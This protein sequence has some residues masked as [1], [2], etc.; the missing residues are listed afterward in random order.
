GTASVPGALL[1]LIARALN[2]VDAPPFD[3]LEAMSAALS[4]HE[5]GDRDRIVRRLIERIAP[6]AWAAGTSDAQHD[7][8]RGGAVTTEYRRLLREADERLYQQ[9]LALE[10]SAAAPA[11]E[12][13][14]SHRT[15]VLAV[16][17]ALAMLVAAAAEALRV[18]S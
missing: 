3:S 17:I 2:D 1:Y 8:R 15:A 10:S 4:R 6:Q 12:T 16:A 7:R 18:G 14:S 13:V 11:V 5:H 9:K